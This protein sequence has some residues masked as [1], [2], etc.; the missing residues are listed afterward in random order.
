MEMIHGASQLL[1]AS[2][3]PH[4]DLDLPSTIWD[5]PIPVDAKRAILGGNA[6]RL[7]GIR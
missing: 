4:Q 1:Y 5:P 3:Y 2:D 6:L 7:F